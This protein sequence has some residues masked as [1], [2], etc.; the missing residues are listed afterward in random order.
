VILGVGGGRV[1]GARVSHSE[2][3][4]SEVRD[5]GGKVAKPVGAVNMYQL[6]RCSKRRLTRRIDQWSGGGGCA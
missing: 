4:E 6:F 5:S 1:E 3:D 2:V